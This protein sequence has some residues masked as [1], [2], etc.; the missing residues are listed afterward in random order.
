MDRSSLAERFAGDGNQTWKTYVL[1]THPQETP[2]QLLADVFG[3]PAVRS[4]DDVHLHEVRAL[5]AS[6]VVDT[7]DSRFWS[8]HTS[9]PASA[10]RRPINAAVTRRHDLDYVWL[11]SS[12]LRAIEHHGRTK[13]VSSDFRAGQFRPENTVHKLSFRA[14]GGTAQQLLDAISQLPDYTYALSLDRVGLLAEDDLL[15][16]V[17]EAVSRMAVFLARG[18]SFA[19]HQQVIAGTIDRYRRLVEAAESLALGFGPFSDGETEH[20]GGRLEGGPIEL[21]FSQPLADFDGFLLQLLSS[22][23]PFRLWG[24]VDDYSERYAEIEAVDLHVGGRIRIEAS[25]D[26]IR[27]FLRRGGCGNTVARLVSNLQHHVD[28]NL[29]ATEPTLEAQL[30]LQPA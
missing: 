4:T 21:R 17:E 15:G 11:P 1:E 2:V 18:Q 23:A 10:A 5:E 3:K 30:S 8:F 14:R 6:Y 16:N 13:F 28:G 20:Y 24:L 9:D 27:V 7:I 19:L 12:H 25:P 22:R 29:R 26:M